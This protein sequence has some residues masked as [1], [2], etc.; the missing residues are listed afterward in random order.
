MQM[1]ISDKLGRLAESGV[2]VLEVTSAKYTELV[3]K[4][5]ASVLRE[6]DLKA[7][8]VTV[9]KSQSFLKNIF[10]K[11]KVNLLN[12]YFIDAVSRDV[13]EPS[14]REE[15]AMFVESP[16]DLSGLSIAIEQVVAQLQKTAQKP[17]IFFDS[18]S[19]LTIYCSVGSV[20]KFVHILTSKIRMQ[21][22]RGIFISIPKATDEKLPEMIKQFCDEVI[23]LE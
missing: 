7:V 5:L 12:L 14:A 20:E 1:D 3:A 23:K 11:F 2:C 4:L 21:G 19:T 15:D 16:G 6:T 9:N 10:N 13:G 22:C 18:I 17:L 8:Y